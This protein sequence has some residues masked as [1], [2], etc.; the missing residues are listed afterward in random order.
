MRAL[1]LV[2]LTTAFLILCIPTFAMESATFD[3]DG[4]QIKY[5]TEG[6]GE[7]VILIHGF[8]ANAQLN[9]IAPGV[10]GALAKDYRVIAPDLRGHGQSGK[11]HGAENYGPQM[12]KD[13]INLMDHL[14]IEKAHIAGYSLGGFLTVYLTANYPDRIICSIPCGAG[15]SAPGSEREALTDEI[16]KSLE[17]GQGITPLIKALTP[18]GRPQPTQEQLD[19][20]NKML[21]TMNDPLALAGAARGIKAL[22]VPKEKIA[23]ITVPMRD[24]IGEI[25][26]LKETVDALKGAN[27]AVDVVVIA[28]GDHMN[29]FGDPAF[30]KALKDFID[31]HAA[32]KHT[33]NSGAPAEKTAAGK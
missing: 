14:K 27:P 33:E 22:A 10:F 31:Q 16:A 4:V 30:A 17:S 19:S 23:A 1:R 28:G 26:P 7:P 32:H 5:V 18:A 15:W 20:M 21:V 12:A 2:A 9:W 13:I 25:D 8:V 11:P 29:T 3:S 6:Q 24:I